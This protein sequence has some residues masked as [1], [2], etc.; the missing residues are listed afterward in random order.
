MDV[1]NYA[2]LEEHRPRCSILEHTIYK[3]FVYTS[4]LHLHLHL[5]FL[6][7]KTKM[8]MIPSLAQPFSKWL[9]LVQRTFVSP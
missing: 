2:P 7:Q 4:L 1:T 5:Q 6:I 8:A 3:S 9:H